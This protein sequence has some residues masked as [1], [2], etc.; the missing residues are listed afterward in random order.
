M[1]VK[2]I[3]NELYKLYYIFKKYDD[4][5]DLWAKIKNEPNI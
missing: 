2:Y 3:D 5:N 1:D 4:Y